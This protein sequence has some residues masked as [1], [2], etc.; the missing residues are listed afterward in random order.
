MSAPLLERVLVL[1]D[2]RGPDGRRLPLTPERRQA[3]EWLALTGYGMGDGPAGLTQR[4]LDLL[5]GARISADTKLPE[6]RRLLGLLWNERP[7][8]PVL[9][10]QLLAL[11]PATVVAPGPSE[12]Q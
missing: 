4:L 6:A 11:A 2:P 5:E 10:E 9:W 1:L 12:V 3:L 8:D 7:I